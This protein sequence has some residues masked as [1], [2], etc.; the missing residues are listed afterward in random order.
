MKK[1]IKLL[2]VLLTI[3]ITSCTSYDNPADYGSQ[4]SETPEQQA[5]WAT[6]DAWKTDSCT[7][8]DDF[9]MHMI[10]SWWKNPTTVYPNGLMPYA[11]L[12]NNSRVNEIYNTNAD[13]RHLYDNLKNAPIM[14]ILEADSLLTAKFDELWAGATTREEALAAVGRAWAEGYSLDYELLVEMQDSVPIWMIDEKIPPYITSYELYSSKEEMWRS[15]A[16][17]QGVRLTRR[18]AQDEWADLQVILN[19]M[20]LDFKDKRI[21]I[22]NEAIEG[23]QYLLNETCSTVDGIKE[24]LWTTVLLLDGPLVNDDLAEQ[25]DHFVEEYRKLK[26]KTKNFTLT[27]QSIM[28]YVYN[29][30]SGFYALNDYIN[31]YITPAIRQQ[32]VDYCEEFRQ[33]MRQRLERNQWLGD[34][35]RK[36]ALEKLDNMEFYVGGTP[37]IP[38]CVIPTLTGKDCIEDIRQLR[39]ARMDGY[40]W[41]ATQSRKNCMVFLDDLLFLRDLTMDYASYYPIFNAVK[42]SPSNLLDPY[43]MDV[44][45]YPLQLAFIATTIGH[46]ITH[47]FDTN[48]SQYDK[49]GNYVNW[50]TDSDAE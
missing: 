7:V 49:W 41:A 16:P 47:A 23:L 1:E 12:V 18:A 39:K 28:S 45:E 40:L 24:Y 17:H 38:D 21:V 6:F 48:G 44:Y 32:Y 35:T 15:R 29:Y 43:V 46:E 9:F 14:G 42:I 19:G 11:G 20:N 22:V 2:L 37:I 25:Y 34:A 30:M 50:W 26:G 5:F 3:G 8:G 10:G 33:A 4:Y 36:N 31:K 27:R 13:L